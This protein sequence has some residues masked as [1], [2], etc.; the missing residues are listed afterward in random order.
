MLQIL[1]SK[2][3][4]G[5]IGYILLVESLT[6][7]DDKKKKKLTNFQIENKSIYCSYTRLNHLTKMLI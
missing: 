5:A 1:C 3:Y 2:H 6:A 4:G 7:C